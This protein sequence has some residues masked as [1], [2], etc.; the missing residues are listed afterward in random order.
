MRTA[1]RALVDS[2]PLRSLPFYS[3]L[4]K[5]LEEGHLF[6]FSAGDYLVVKGEED[7]L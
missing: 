2:L 7:F 5:T 3:L 4:M 1:L 6:P